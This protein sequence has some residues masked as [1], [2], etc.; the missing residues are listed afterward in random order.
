MYFERM[1]PVSTQLL[2]ELCKMA[3][4]CQIRQAE[5]LGRPLHP[6]ELRW[7]VRAAFVFAGVLDTVDECHAIADRVLSLLNSMP[8]DISRELDL[9]P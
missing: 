6:T 1:Q 3:R 9:W 7:L 4:T 8:S 2:I 5:L